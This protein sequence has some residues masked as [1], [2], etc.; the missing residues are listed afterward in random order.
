[1]AVGAYAEL[2]TINPTFFFRRNKFG[3]WNR[4]TFSSL[5]NDRYRSVSKVAIGGE[6]AFLALTTL[7]SLPYQVE[8]DGVVFLFQDLGSGTMT[9]FQKLKSKDYDC[10]YFGKTA[11]ILGD[12]SIMLSCMAQDDIGSILYFNKTDVDDTQYTLQ[13]TVYDGAA[14][15]NNDW[16]A[17]DG[18]SN[19]KALAIHR[20]SST[21]GFYASSSGE[22][23]NEATL[24]NPINGS[25][26]EGS[27][28][29]SESA[30]LVQTADNVHVYKLDES[31]EC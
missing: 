15:N 12:G 22:E 5:T 23:W 25:T 27:I 2:G 1:M 21:I 11:E 6:D 7:T 30:M 14:S 3:S 4:E 24:A 10:K 9:L 31:D 13:Q 17:A 20:G 8:N 28:A 29:V 26:S 16:F 19:D 18:T